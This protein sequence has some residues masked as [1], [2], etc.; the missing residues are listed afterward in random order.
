MLFEESLNRIIRRVSPFAYLDKPLNN[1]Q[2]TFIFKF[3]LTILVLTPEG[4]VWLGGTVVIVCVS[5]S[6]SIEGFQLFPISV[7]CFLRMTLHKVFNEG[8]F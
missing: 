4:T 1:L 7:D 5:C 8:C 2:E 6:F 3:D